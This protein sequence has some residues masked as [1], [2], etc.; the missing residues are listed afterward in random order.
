MT[1]YLILF[2]AF[3]LLY[4]V[5]EAITYYRQPTRSER[6]ALLLPLGIFS[7]LYAG[8]IGTD[9]ESYSMLFDI[10]EEYPL[11]PGFA[12]LMIGAKMIGFDYIDF[13]K[14][15]AIAQVL[16]LASIVKR[17]RDPLL[18]IFFYFSAF[19]LNFHFNAVRNSFALLIIGAI[20]VRRHKLGVTTLLIS[21]T[22][23]YSSLMTLILLRLSESRRKLL[24]TGII[25]IIGVTAF[26]LSPDLF[27]YQGHLE[28]DYEAKSVYMALLLKLVIMWLIYLNGGS[29]FFLSTYAI[30]VVLIHVASPI[31]SR[32]SDLVLFLALLEFCMHNRLLHLRKYIIALISVLMISSFM[33]PLNDCLTVGYDNWCLSGPNAR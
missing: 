20:Y 6:Y 24:A 16:L 21:S 19:Y 5:L 12:Q 32:V 15:L 28:Q 11:E 9:V 2:I 22:I 33:I 7:L 3:L 18:F 13:T 4:F 14:L 17:L 8:R 25:S 30:L 31:L 10:A 29:R 23:H 1:S 27:I 26:L